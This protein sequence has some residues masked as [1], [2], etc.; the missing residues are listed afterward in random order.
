[1]SVVPVAETV[2]RVARLLPGPSVVYRPPDGAP[3]WLRIQDLV[4]DDGALLDR[5]LAEL[6][7][8]RRAGLDVAGSSLLVTAT[9][10][11]ARPLLAALVT[12]RRVPALTDVALQV[13]RQGWFQR[14]ALQSPEMAV[15]P[16][17][18]AV[19]SP[20]VV[21]VADLEALRRQ[22]VDELLTHL[23]PLVEALRPRSH[24]GP[25]ALWGVVADVTAIALVGVAH[26][27]RRPDSWPEELAALLDAAPALRARP[28][29]VAYA[30]GRGE[31][32]FLRRSAC[33]LAYKGDGGLDYC[34]TCPLVPH[35]EQERRMRAALGLDPA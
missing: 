7:R 10:V 13:H 27:V 18:P 12:E 9:S 29:A 30:H 17:D 25:Y 31:G 34:A 19:G 16:G 33:C 23:R 3:R 2:E 22:L 1:M 32:A 14:L 6:A 28:Q 20:G 26:A 11:L 35:P 24:R 5:Q 4:A 15:L 8:R 21:A